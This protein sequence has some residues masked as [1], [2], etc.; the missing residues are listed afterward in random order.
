MRYLLCSLFFILSFTGLFAQS[1]FCATNDEDF[2]HIKRSATPLKG[3]KSVDDT[4]YVSVYFF[5]IA[6]DQASIPTGITQEK[7]DEVV[8]ELNVQFNPYGIGIENCQELFIV[9]NPDFASKDVTEVAPQLQAQQHVQGSISVFINPNAHAGASAIAIKSRDYIGSTYLGFTSKIMIHEFGHMFSLPH[10]HSKDELVNGT[11]CSFAGD[12]FCDTPADPNLYLIVDENC[13]MT[14]TRKDANGDTYAPLI[15]NHMSYSLA[16]CRSAFTPEQVQAMQNDFTQNIQAK[17]FYTCAYDTVNSI[18]RFPLFGSDCLGYVSDGSGALNYTPGIQSSLLLQTPESND[19]ITLTFEQFDTELNKDV[20]RIYDGVDNTAPLLLEHSGNTLPETIQATGNTVFIEFITN[21]SE[22]HGGWVAYYSC[23]NGP[24][25]EAMLP[26]WTFY[27]IDEDTLITKVLITNH[28][29]EAS[30]VVQSKLRIYD[31]AHLFND[32]DTSIF[33]ETPVVQPFDTVQVNIPYNI[34]LLEAKSSSRGSYKFELF[35]DWFNVMKERSRGNNFQQQS[36][37]GDD[38]VCTICSEKSEF[39]ISTDSLEDGSTPHQ[40]YEV[41]LECSWLIETEPGSHINAY[42]DYVDIAPYNNFYKSGDSL[43]IYNGSDNTAPILA[44]ISGYGYE[45]TLV[46]T[47]NQIYLTFFSD[48]LGNSQGGGS[49]LGW[50]M[51]YYSS[52]VSSVADHDFTD[53]S[54]YPNPNESGVFTF[55]KPLDHPVTLISSTGEQLKVLEVGT[56]S[57]EIP[58]AGLYFLRSQS[59][60]VVKLI[61]L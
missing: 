55:S 38:P 23:F 60:S 30:K 34:C 18:I 8:E 48:S 21:D 41:D 31:I 58:Q 4:N 40:R 33:F 12:K 44:S 35:I 26:F 37:I 20:L 54:V 42:F 32:A 25:L 5:L 56:T 49:G 16:S 45:D 61:R 43:V 1:T 24:D 50:K 36:S 17:H 2:K 28:G 10:T 47:S 6:A 22:E 14:V 39:N 52:T 51:H 27:E 59:G 46:S 9:I 13:E 15:D 19:K 29:T 11:N 53:L 3:Y 57:F 7:V